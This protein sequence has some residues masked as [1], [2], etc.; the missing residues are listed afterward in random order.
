MI[1]ITKNIRGDEL[2]ANIVG[3]SRHICIQYEKASALS[4][5]PPHN[6]STPRRQRPLHFTAEEIDGASLESTGKNVLVKIDHATGCGSR[7]FFVLR[8]VDYDQE[9][10]SKDGTGVF[11]FIYESNNECEAS[12]ISNL[13][14][15]LEDIRWVL[16]PSGFS[17]NSSELRSLSFKGANACQYFLDLSIDGENG[18]GDFCKIIR[19]RYDGSWRSSMAGETTAEVLKDGSA[20]LEVSGRLAEYF[21]Y[22]FFS[23][24]EE[25]VYIPKS[26]GRGNLN[27]FSRGSTSAVCGF[28]S[29][30]LR[31]DPFPSFK[32]RF[33]VDSDGKLHAFSDRSLENSNSKPFLNEWEDAWRDFYWRKVNSIVSPTSEAYQ[34]MKAGDDRAEFDFQFYG[35]VAKVLFDLLKVEVT[36][37]SWGP[38]I[39]VKIKNGAQLWCLQSS[40]PDN[41][42]TDPNQSLKCRIAFESTGE[43]LRPK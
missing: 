19:Q 18:N 33:R 32:C 10:N 12:T 35:P 27:Y 8:P 41:F 17:D 20:L 21:F 4:F 11:Q 5:W 3:S 42:S 9:D 13:Q 14:Y 6:D 26:N 23:A 2:F 28:W 22:H 31:K 39:K 38:D 7:D 16:E 15:A 24:R 37:S 1:K 40:Q 36:D 29:W 25:V 30:D 34:S 43:A